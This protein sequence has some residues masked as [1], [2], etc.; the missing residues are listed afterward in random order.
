M[1]NRIDA[2]LDRRR[3][4]GTAVLAPFVTYGYPNEETSLDIARA[5][6]DAGGDLLELGVPFSDPLADGPTIQMTSSRALANGVT[7]ERCIGGVRTLRER[8]TT[9]PMVIMGYVNPF[10]SYG[11]ERFVRDSASAGADGVIVPDL[12]TEESKHLSMACREEGLHLIPLLA[13]TSTDERIASACAGAGGFI[14][15]VSLT[16]VTGARG[17][18]APGPRRLVERIRAH[19][20]L[21]ILVGFGV[22]RP[23]H[24]ADISAFA[25]GA[26]FASAMLDAI[27]RSPA[28]AAANVAARFVRSLRGE[29]DLP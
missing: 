28:D 16:G 9:E 22:S 19:S 6:L 24:V 20:D 5:A 11:L 2:A 12:P 15:C 4:E 18:M 14:Y 25:D 17:R 7:V 26:V 13:P 8:G 10:L 23:E 21:P 27:E 29:V 1:A 3:T